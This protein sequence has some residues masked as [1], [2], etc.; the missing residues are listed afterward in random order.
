MLSFYPS[1]DLL[2][3]QQKLS[4]TKSHEVNCHLRELITLSLAHFAL[5][6]AA[7][8][9]IIGG[10]QQRKV[11]CI[12]MGL[13]NVGRYKPLLRHVMKSVAMRHA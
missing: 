3:H 13:C 11:P 2:A 5:H 8:Y 6:N 9:V 10:P 12:T 1:R 4:L 7:D